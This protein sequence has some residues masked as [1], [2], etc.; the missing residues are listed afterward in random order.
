MVER[1]RQII[2]EDRRHTFDEISMLVE[3][4]HGTCHKILTEDLKM[5][6]VA[7]ESV[8]RLMSVDQKRQRLDICLDLKKILP[9]SPAFF[10]MSLRVTRPGFTPTTQ[11]PKLSPVSGKVRG[12]LERRRQGN[13]KSTLVCFL[14]QRGI[15]HKEFV[16]PGQTANAAFYVEVLKCLRENVQRKRPDQWRN[17]TRLLHHDN[18]PNPY[19]PPDSTVSDR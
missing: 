6:R 3:I 2:R 4:S 13:I 5:R 17:N 19:C 18:T 10:R 1:V 14:D 8:P 11:K 16:P 9:T 15:V 7:S 12:D